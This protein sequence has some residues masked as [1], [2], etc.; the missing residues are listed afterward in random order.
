MPVADFNIWYKS[1]IESFLY[2]NHRSNIK[3]DWLNYSEVL[4]GKYK[5]S[6]LKPI[7][8]Y[9]EN[10]YPAPRLI[11]IENNVVTLEYLSFAEIM[12]LQRKHEEQLSAMEKVH[13]RQFYLS[14]ICDDSNSDCFQE[15]YR[16]FIPWVLD[17]PGKIFKIS[18]IEDSPFRVFEKHSRFSDYECLQQIDPEM[19]FFQF[20]KVGDH[21]I[22]SEYGKIP[23][24]T[25]TFRLEFDADDIMIK[26]I[27][28]FYAK[29]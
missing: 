10:L 13:M 3:D 5:D 18:T 28:E 11:S 20:R 9:V 25:P 1:T 4:N 29:D 14:D 19:L 8:K 7:N 22:D 12:L 24:N 23:K 15:V 21:M 27:K 2:I 6:V 26:R 17:S 16:L